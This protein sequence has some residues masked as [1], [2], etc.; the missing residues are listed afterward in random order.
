ISSRTKHVSMMHLLMTTNLHSSRLLLA[1]ALVAFFSMPD[2]HAQKRHRAKRV[3][4][5]RTV[6][7]HRVHRAHYR[8]RHLPRRRV[9]VAKVPNGAVV[10]RHRNVRY[11]FYG[12]VCYRPQGSGFVVVR[13]PIGLRV[14]VL[15][16]GYQRL[17]VRQRT[18][19][20]Y[21]GTYYAAQGDQYAVI[22]APEGA[23]VNALPEGY[24]TVEHAGEEFLELDDVYYRPVQDDAGETAYQVVPKPE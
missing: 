20:Y 16:V 17:V 23:T 18:V 3:H 7:R 4:H 21:Y 24:N 8:Y 5:K 2:G 11:R 1:L 15:P 6:K 13:A 10:I 22:D 14:A 9:V 12:G 19:Y